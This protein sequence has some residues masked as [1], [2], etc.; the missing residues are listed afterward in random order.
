MLRMGHVNS[1][2]KQIVPKT[3]HHQNKCCKWNKA[4]PSKSWKGM[5]MMILVRCTG[6][7]ATPH[8][9][10]THLLPLYE[11]Q[12]WIYL[13]VRKLRFISNLLIIVFV[14]FLPIA[15]S[16]VKLV[17]MRAAKSLRSMMEP[18]SWRRHGWIRRGRGEMSEDG[19]ISWSSGLWVGALPEYWSSRD[20]AANPTPY[21][22]A[23]TSDSSY[24]SSLIT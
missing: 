5:W 12:I 3:I 2:A 21:Y 8:T 15:I 22:K 23:Y 17:I 24:P 14:V 9:A 20:P 18:P 4:W 19:R 10:L 16:Q 11:V 13:N 1:I 7:T 6:K